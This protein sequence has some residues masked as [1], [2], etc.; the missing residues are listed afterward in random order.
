MKS[1][2]NLGCGS[3]KLS[4]Y[5]NV[6]KYGEPDVKFDLETFPW[7]WQD[8]QVTEVV[9]HHVLEHLGQDKDTFLNIIQE[10]Y[11]VCAHEAKINIRVPHPRHDHFLI[12]PTHCRVIL[13]ETL[14]MFSKEANTYWQEIGAANT[15]LALNLN[16]D[17]E[18]VSQ[19]Q[20]YDPVWAEKLEKKHITETAL[21]ELS[22]LYNNVI[23]EYKIVLK[24][25]KPLR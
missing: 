4:G 23:M 3:N 9:L 18:I 20:V 19:E 7:P 12:D 14:V 25:I 17:F 1:K 11:R 16:V 2:L 13:P 22:R 15:P 10:L 21:Q 8:N 5:I 6:D 24:V